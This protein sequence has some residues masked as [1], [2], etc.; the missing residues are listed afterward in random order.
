MRDTTD[1][2]L[3]TE[4]AAMMRLENFR[5]FSV[6]DHE[7]HIG[8]MIART[9]ATTLLDYGCG[10]AGAYATPNKVHKR[11]GVPIPRLYDPAW[12]PFAQKPAPGEI[13]DGVICNDVLE[14]IPQR[15]VDAVIEDLFSY[16]R[17][18]VFASVC[19]RPAKKKFSDGSNLHVTIKPYAWW[20]YR[21]DIASRGQEWVLIETF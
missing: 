1:P 3:I 2:K 4:Y 16:A 11:W 18:F 7:S 19:C 20:R 21:F 15:H 14:H 5:G 8:E 6:L 9:E 17:L 13:F 12:P 10:R